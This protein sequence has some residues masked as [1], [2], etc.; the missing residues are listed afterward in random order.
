[1]SRPVD[2]LNVLREGIAKAGSLS[3]YA[4]QIGCSAAYLSDIV[5]GRREM[6]EKVCKALGL[7]RVVTYHRSRR[8]V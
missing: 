8:D 4:R 6:G 3:A 1:M 5:N 7:E 2:Q